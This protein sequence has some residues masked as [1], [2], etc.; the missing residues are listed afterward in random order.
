MAK[1]PA[2]GEGTGVYGE[3]LSTWIYQAEYW[4]VATVSGSS[5]DYTSTITSASNGMSWSTGTFESQAST[6]NLQ[7]AL[8]TIA[9]TGLNNQLVNTGRTLTL[10]SDGTVELTGPLQLVSLTDSQ[11]SGI[12]NPKPGMMVFNSD[13]GTIQVY[14]GFAWGTI[15]IS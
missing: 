3:E 1:L 14:T 5:D 15:A 8:R 10:E 13:N 11:I 9:R 2:N 12:Q 6:R 7:S 4:Q